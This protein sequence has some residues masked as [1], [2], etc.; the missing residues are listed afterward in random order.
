M[1]CSVGSK[2]LVTQMSLPSADRACLGLWPNVVSVPTQL[3]VGPW[4]LRGKGQ[5]GRRYSVKSCNVR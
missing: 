1:I 2:R 3:T 4:I 5:P